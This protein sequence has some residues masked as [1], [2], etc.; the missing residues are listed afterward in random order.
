MATLAEIRQKYPQYSD[1]PDADLADR[2][3]RKFYADMPREEFDAKVG[4]QTQPAA[5]P[6]PKSP[7]A[8]SFAA[9]AAAG[10]PLPT[11]DAG[12]VGRD[13]KIAVQGAGRGMADLVG[14]PADLSTG[15]ANL[16][17]G[18]ADKGGQGAQW[19]LEALLPGWAEKYVPD[20]GVDYRF[21]PSPLGADSI[22]AGADLL[23]SKAGVET[24][25]P[26][27]M[28][29]FE[30]TKYNVNRFGSQAVVGGGGLA[31]AAMKEA[32]EMAARAPKLL[33]AFL[34]PYIENVGK[35]LKVDA[36]AGAGA[37][38]GLTAEQ[39]VVPEDSSLRPIADFMAM[40]L[41]GGGAAT[42]ASAGRSAA[43]TAGKV[44][45]YANDRGIDYVKNEK[46]QMKGTP[47]RI[48]DR[49]ARFFQ[50]QA[51]DADAAVGRIDQRASDARFYGEPLPTVGL[52]SDDIG[53]VAAEKGLRVKYSKDF[54]ERDQALRT[55]ASEK[56][57]GLNDISA[58]P[59][60]ATAEVGRQ[61]AV[62][63]DA[64]QA[65]VDNAAQNTEMVEKS[66][67]AEGDKLAAN[68]DPTGQASADL[69]E[70][71]GKTK[72]A[73][74]AKKAGLYREA[75]TLAKDVK[76]DPSPLA[77]DAV[78]IKDEISKLAGHSP[79]LNNVLDDLARLAPKDETVDTGLL[80]ATGAPITKAAP[81]EDITAADL[82]AMRP[83]LSRARD[84]A[85]KLVRGDVVE[86]LDRVNAGLVS[87]L[88]KLADGGNAAALKWQ[89]AEANFKSDFA[90]KYRE[91][92]G[93][94]LDKAERAK[95]PVPPSAMA[96]HL[97]K[98][99][100]GGKEAAENLRTILKGS[101]VEADGL[102]AGRRVLLDWAAG[103]VGVDGKVSPHR[104]KIWRDKY[105]GAIG[106]IPGLKDEIDQAVR[107]ARGGADLE[108]K[109]LGELK[110]AQKAQK[111]TEEQIQKSAAGILLD[112]DPIKA[113]TR[114]LNLGPYEAPKK[115]AEIVRLFKD[116]PE[117]AK[118]WKQAVVEH[119]LFKVRTTRQGVSG[120]ASD[121][122]KFF[123]QNEKTL[124]EVFTGAGEMHALHRAQK[125]LEPLRNL[126]R[127][128]ITGSATS[129][130]DML[131]N[132][133]E[134]G[135]LA[136]TGNAITAGMIMKRVRV[137]LKFL[138]DE[139]AQ[140]REFVKRA[141]LDPDLAKMLLT[142]KVADIN[143]P[144]WNKKLTRIL[145]AGQASRADA[146]ENE[147]Q[148]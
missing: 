88:N 113:A 57:E 31:K 105:A 59:T 33:D 68:R 19:L 1:L 50:N 53:L 94:Q 45:G 5:E 119:M 9:L 54:E 79:E 116:S 140:L 70:A 81:V 64:A 8:D 139:D 130:N 99:G 136:V 84:A 120:D 123:E 43:Q 133:V 97:L 37:G 39:A 112:E 126:R 98:A 92:V 11:R 55:W 26:E 129:E 131:W 111:M 145:A 125:M 13:L 138:P 7:L 71:V 90:P 3:Y 108:N 52:A 20:M 143:N 128:A 134:A 78:A 6:E 85:R 147:E 46:G 66:R 146:A 29:L 34:M 22:A 60:K 101:P 67:V 118:G 148:P 142:R 96:G 17:L 76:V 35:A 91:G 144:A 28:S 103:V 14:M 18:T 27:Q 82:I 24:V 49:A 41:G 121:L 106:Q 89:E 93:G 40:M 32:P 62:K 42:A 115:M 16:A 77:D 4:L 72:E 104:F 86:R 21:Q 132:S 12:D 74:T 61:T 127:Q 47:K 36:A 2:L 87:Q 51:S 44:R 65:E 100:P 63:R 15:A 135:L 73:D 23:A 114:V 30:K 95:T 69:S 10:R 80:D 56:V 141:M 75:E 38:V 117:A 25:E 109:F 48:A 107:A 110:A 83:R 102:A 137:A 122:M 124:A 58:D